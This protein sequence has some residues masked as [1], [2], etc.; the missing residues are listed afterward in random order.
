MVLLDGKQLAEK[1]IAELKAEVASLNKKLRL[2]VI[3]V[4]N[5]PVVTKFIA[6]KRKV[7]EQIGIDF[8]I[9]PFEGAVTSSELRSR[10]AEIVHEKKNTGVI[11]QLPL[12]AHIGKQ[13]MLN[14]IIPQKDVDVLSSRAIGNVV[15]GTNPVISPVASAV[16]ALFEEYKI[17]YVGKHIVIM[18]AGALV[19]KPVALWL[20]KEKIGYSIVTEETPNI[21]DVLMQADIVISG[22]GKPKFITGDMVK[23][24]VVIIDA[25][26][27]ESAG[28]LSGDVDFD[29]VN[30]KASYIT[31]V[32]GGVG[33]VTV[34][35]LFKNL[36]ELAKLQK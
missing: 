30:L 33:P 19:G 9:F 27:S 18:G 36:V 26:T 5:D 15:A 23:N 29:S 32:P 34:A 31:P 1:I 17:E 20:L 11:I 25:G 3:V 4:G 13:H 7:A 35:M 21:A 6:Q 2:A 8:R 10:V 16:K 12:P 22:I 28:K 24:N 14:A